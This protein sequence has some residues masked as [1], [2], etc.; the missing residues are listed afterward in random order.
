[1]N[2]IPISANFINTE[3]V[4]R[5]IQSNL[6]MSNIASPNLLTEMALLKWLIPQNNLF[7]LNGLN[8]LASALLSQ[9]SMN[10]N[11]ANVNYQANL[12]IPKPVGKV[13]TPKIIIKEKASS[14]TA[15]HKLEVKW[16]NQGNSSKNNLESS[17]VVINLTNQITFGLFTFKFNLVRENILNCINIIE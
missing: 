10:L 2:N 1:M 3:A 16:E 17:K 13:F 6:L 15:D 4:C 7:E 14:M 5:L 8:S 11:Q 9:Y 12:N